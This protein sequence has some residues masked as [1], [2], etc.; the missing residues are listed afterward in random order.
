MTELVET[1]NQ[2]EVLKCLNVDRDKLDHYTNLF[3]KWIASQKHL[4]QNMTEAGRKKFLIWAKLDF[5]KAKKKFQNFCYNPLTHKEFSCGRALRYEDDIN[6][7]FEF[8]YLIP[9]PKLTPEAARVSCVKLFNC[10]HFDALTM[11]RYVTVHMEFKVRIE[12]LVTGERVVF[13]M[14]C[15]KPHHYAK[16]FTPT[17][18]KLFKFSAVHHPFAIKDFFVVNC[19]PLLEKGVGLMKAVLPRKIADRVA[20][21]SDP[22]DLN[23]RI[24]PECLPK[25]YGG[26]EKSLDDFQCLWKKYWLS[27]KDYYVELERYK[28]SGS[29]PEEFKD[30]ENEFGLDGSFR[31]LN[32]D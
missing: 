11:A 5:E 31:K 14:E 26:T 13:D 12:N 16:I 24:P 10:D 22:K 9:M 28:P 7:A 18:L 2:N 27:H 32:I 15:M 1:Q 19:H 25:D 29:V 3:S 17:F 30:Y 4:P 8:L 23:K 21:L 20:I 6:R